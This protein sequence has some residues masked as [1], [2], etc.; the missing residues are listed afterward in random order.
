MN[1][2]KIKR[3]QMRF[4]L[5]LFAMQSTCILMAQKTDSIKSAVY[6]FDKIQPKKEKTSTSRQIFKGSTLDLAYF[7][8]HATTLE[9]G[10]APHAAHT[11]G[12]TEELI[13]VKQG[14]VKLTI[15][16][17]S[18]TL[19]ASSVAV[20]MPGDEHGIEN[21][22]KDNATYYIVKLKSRAATDRERAAK[23]G[24][25][26]MV[27]WDTATVKKT[28]KGQHRDIFDRPTSQFARFDVH[29]TTLNAGQVSHLPHTHRSEEMLVMIKGNVQMNIGN[30]FYK[31]AAGDV[32]FLESEIPHALNNTG[33]TACEYF[34]FQWKN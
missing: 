34:A 6:P 30:K 28:D 29:A 3:W 14:I 7:E 15:N 9:P 13:I 2:I 17:H 33:K 24:G 27:N 26:F 5:L 11:H 4:L 23:A 16:G 8:M 31:A 25:S 10:K 19:G 12:D 20:V 18:K 21:A 32:I 22:G 1:S